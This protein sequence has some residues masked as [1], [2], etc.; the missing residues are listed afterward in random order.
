M[1]K[2]GALGV[3]TLRLAAAALIL[4]VVCRRRCAAI[5]ARTGARCSPSVSRWA[6]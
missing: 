6:V 4:L 5:R 3:V 1:P 2:A